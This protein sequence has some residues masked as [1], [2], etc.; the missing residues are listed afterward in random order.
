MDGGDM[1]A[2]DVH[3]G[4]KGVYLGHGMDLASDLD[5]HI[6]SA[7]G[8]GK[9]DGHGTNVDGLGKGGD[10]RGADSKGMGPSKGYGHGEGVDGVGKGV[11]PSLGFNP[12]RSVFDFEWDRLGGGI[13]AAVHAMGDQVHHAA[14]FDTVPYDWHPNYW[15]GYLDGYTSS[16]QERDQACAGFLKCLCWANS[17]N[18]A[19][20]TNPAWKWKAATWHGGPWHGMADLNKFPRFEYQ[21]GAS[22]WEPYDEATQDK[23]REASSSLKHGVPVKIELDYGDGWSYD[24]LL[25]YSCPYYGT[26]GAQ[27]NKHTGSVRG[28][29]IVWSR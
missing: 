29:R 25:S 16:A 1:V 18:D 17:Y 23:L 21:V 3:T 12:P 15:D 26:M 10:G 19:S 7:F 13:P 5:I 4:G 8:S 27:R 9:G 11:D 22:Q 2:H 24:I 6:S 14:G 28:I 20:N